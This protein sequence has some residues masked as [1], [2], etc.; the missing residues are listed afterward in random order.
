M[1]FEAGD[2]TTLAVYAAIDVLEFVHADD[3][4]VPTN[5]ARPLEL[6][7]DRVLAIFILNQ[8]ALLKACTPCRVRTASQRCRDSA[9]TP[10]PSVSMHLNGHFVKL[11][12]GVQW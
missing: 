1:S 6:R 5:Q 11:V 3:P 2:R 9:A 4:G 7:R 12:S 8:R 10:S